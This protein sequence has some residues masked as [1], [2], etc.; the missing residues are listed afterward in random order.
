MVQ[1]GLIN[2]DYADVRAVMSGK[3]EREGTDLLLRTLTP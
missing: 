3:K 2:L 1:P